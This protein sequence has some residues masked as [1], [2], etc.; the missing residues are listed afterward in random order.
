MVD[1]VVD[2]VFLIKFCG[3]LIPKAESEIWADLGRLGSLDFMN[4]MYF[5]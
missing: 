2:K 3:G 4:S 1:G 5:S